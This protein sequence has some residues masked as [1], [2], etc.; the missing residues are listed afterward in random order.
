MN[1]DSEESQESIPDYANDSSWLS[2][3][4]MM[5]SGKEAAQ[6]IRAGHMRKK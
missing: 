6:I 3:K 4:G 1:L 5:R 2:E